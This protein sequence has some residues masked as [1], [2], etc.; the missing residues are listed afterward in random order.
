MNTDGFGDI[1]N[2]IIS[3]LT[4]LE[5]W[6]YAVTH[7]GKG[8]GSEVWR[9]QTCDNTDWEQ[10]VD[11]GLGSEYSRRMPAIETINGRLILVLGDNYTGIRILASESGDVDS[12]YSDRAGWA[13]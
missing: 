4:N 6:L 8:A 10:V 1:A 11:N 2:S 12:W 5:G 13:W 9:C 3:G 7:H